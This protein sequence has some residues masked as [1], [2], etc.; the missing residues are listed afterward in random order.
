[1]RVLGLAYCSDMTTQNEM[2][3]YI[4]HRVHLEAGVFTPTGTLEAAVP[5]TLAVASWGGSAGTKISGWTLRIDGKDYPAGA[6]PDIEI[7]D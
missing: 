6:N 2:Q 3:K 5:R 7:L 1:M 4:G